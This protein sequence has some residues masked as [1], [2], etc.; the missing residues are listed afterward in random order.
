M[1]RTHFLV[2]Q[3][4]PWDSGFQSAGSNS[5]TWDCVSN[6]YFQVQPQATG[7]EIPEW[8]PLMLAHV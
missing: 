5:T 6:V 4:S 7:S 2:A 3:D 8:N 1:P